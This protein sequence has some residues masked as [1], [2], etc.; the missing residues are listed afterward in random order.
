ML[1][2]VPGAAAGGAT[3]AAPLGV[4]LGC[5]SEGSLPNQSQMHFH[6]SSFVIKAKILFG[7]LRV[8]Q[9]LSPIKIGLL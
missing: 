2:V 1:C 9:N 6:L 7:F 5:L 4:G 8:T 3:H